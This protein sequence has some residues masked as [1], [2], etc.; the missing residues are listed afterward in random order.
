MKKDRKPDQL[1][2]DAAAARAAGMSYGKW[3]ATQPQRQTEPKPQKEYYIK[4]N[5]PVCGG[6]FMV[7]TPNSRKKYCCDVCK[8]RVNNRTRRERVKAENDN[9]A[10]S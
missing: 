3:R 5:C 8:Q 7:S 9:C 2:I 10:A 1:A 4:R 6:E